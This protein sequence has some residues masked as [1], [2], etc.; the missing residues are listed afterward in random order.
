MNKP[1]TAEIR[2]AATGDYAEQ[3]VPWYVLLDR[4]EA[5]EQTLKSHKPILAAA[6]RVAFKIW[7]SDSHS[8]NEVKDAMAGLICEIE[9][10]EKE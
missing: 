7:D 4:L 6:R 5:A 1:T 9:N 2:K 10:L 3:L 8:W